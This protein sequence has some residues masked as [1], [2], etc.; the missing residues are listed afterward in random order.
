MRA[1]DY[2]FK[3]KNSAFPEVEFVTEF[4]SP[5]TVG[6]GNTGDQTAD[7]LRL[8]VDS[9][10]KSALLAHQPPPRRRNDRSNWFL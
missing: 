9:K 8:V 7:G 1:S 2:I 4:C 10:L 5:I 3:R 6:A